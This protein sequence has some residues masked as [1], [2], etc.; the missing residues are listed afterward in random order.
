MDLVAGDEDGRVAFVENLGRSAAGMPAFAQPQYFRQRAEFVKFGALA[1]PVGFDWDGDGDEDIVAGNSAGYIGFIEN[2]DGG[3]PP[4]FAAPVRLA[5]RRKNDSHS[6]GRQRLDSR[7][8]R[9][10]VGLHHDQRCRLGWG[11]AARHRSQLDLGRI[12]WHPQR[13]L[14]L[15]TRAGAGPPRSC[16]LGRRARRPAWN[17]WLPADNELVS[18]WRTRPVV[19]DWNRD[20]LQDIVMLDH[21][22]YLR[23][24]AARAGTE[25]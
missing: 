15:Q 11:F 20:G 8:R 22:G 4:K 21:E 7:P 17:W 19:T 25:S 24:S 23:G 16:G 12:V 13:G 3:S 14:A 2:L 18:Q 6:S 1:T 5:G 9:S 10:E